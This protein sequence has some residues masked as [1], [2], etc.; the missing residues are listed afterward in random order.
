[1]PS[2]LQQ[3]YANHNYFLLMFSTVSITPM[4]S[5]NCI[6]SQKFI[7]I[8]VDPFQAV[9]ANTGLTDL[10]TLFL[11]FNTTWRSVFDI[12]PRHQYWLNW[13]VFGPRASL[14]VHKKISYPTRIQ[15]S[16][17]PPLV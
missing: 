15:T 16:D 13:S 12:T 10:N 4:N 3:R 5:V 17:H 11:N 1:L 6:Q 7:Y 14:D 9:K 2:I 8:K